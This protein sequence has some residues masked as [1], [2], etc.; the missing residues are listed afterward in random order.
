[1]TADGPPLCQII[2]HRTMKFSILIPAFKPFYL[3]EAIESVLAQTYKDFEVIIVDDASP[4]DLKSVVEQFHDER[5]SFHR[6]EKG[7]GGYNVVGNWNRCLELAKGEYS[8]CMGDDDRLLPNC[9]A[10]YAKLIERYPDLD[11]FHMR[12]EMINEKSEFMDLQEER[13]E[14]ESVLSMIF[15]QWKGRKQFIGDFLF[16]TEALRAKGG[17]MFTPYAWSADKLTTYI[18]A[19]EKGIANAR[20]PGFQYRINSHTISL[21]PANIKEK[22]K[23]LQMEKNWYIEFFKTY[24][25]PSDNVEQRYFRYLEKEMEL[26]MWR[27]FVQLLRY[28]LKAYPSH[29]KYWMEHKAEYGFTTKQINESLINGLHQRIMRKLFR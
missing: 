10:D 20:V 11:I 18:V 2:T 23:A 15:H 1:M 13:P 4:H 16:R 5:I 22:M 14:W 17:F 6:N 26:F 25:C 19:A 12:T 27:R 3:K 29:R 9:L 8:L 24:N 7:F 28:D 21:D